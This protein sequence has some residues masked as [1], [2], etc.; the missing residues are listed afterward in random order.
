MASPNAQ[1]YPFAVAAKAPPAP[2]DA[3]ERFC[4]RFQAAR[5]NRDLV[6][7]IIDECYEFALP[8]RERTNATG[9]SAKRTDRL[10]DGTAPEALQ[11]FASQMLDDI[12][13]TDARPFDLIAGRE[14]PPD[15]KDQL[16]RL[17]TEVA[18]DII[19]TTNNSDFR[20]ASSE[21]LSD[22]GIGQGILMIDAGDAI[23][24]V[25]F[26]CLPL[27]Q[28]VLTAGPFGRI[29]GLYREREVKASEITTVWPDARL[30]DEM[31][32]DAADQ[33][34]KIYKF[35]EG[36]WRDWSVRGTETWRYMCVAPEK[37]KA[38]KDGVYQGAGSCPFVAPSFMRVAGEVY[39]RGPVQIALPDIKTLNLVKEMILENA[40]LAIGGLWSVEDDGV[41]NVDT[42]TL[43]S[44]TIIPKAPGS[45][46]L[47]PLKTPG[48]FQVGDIIIKDLQAGVREAL[49]KN[50]LGP[51][52]QTPRSA[53]E[54]M[55]RSA[56]RAKRLTG[57]AGRLFTEF[58]F[59]LVRR[60]A[61]IRMQQGAI[62][63][64]AIDG[65]MVAI[66]PL[67]PLTRLQ[68]QDEILRADRFLE[69]YG[70]RFGA[71]AAGLLVKQDDY[72]KW[73]ADKM[74]FNPNL[75]RNAV[76]LKQ[77][78]AALAPLVQQAAA[79]GALPAPKAA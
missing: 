44:G 53:T 4:K 51:L 11:S 65:R 34:D 60:V 57:P 69:L 20:A 74:G 25:R 15:I 56:D 33:P 29:D 75:I 28:A 43:Q 73:L 76:E 18:D 13:P 78:M 30:D 58:L 77:A 1:P 55:Q 9:P 27:S 40:D 5:R 46:G 7:T 54:I 70:L 12:W 26:S 72:G 67:S 62:R 64:P 22:W 48:N 8:L 50:D 61:H 35:V 45:D 16:N 42:I 38:V 10:F 31:R 52:D 2:N 24:P 39:G 36:V 6:S 49:F 68:A 71:Q 32:R 79:S 3:I 66:R 23:D 17:L 63:V 19:S 21:M 59:P 37:R 14:I 47:Q 41:V